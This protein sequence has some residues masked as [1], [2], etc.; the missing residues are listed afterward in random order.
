MIPALN[1]FDTVREFI[2]L[3]LMLIFFA[4]SYN[5]IFSYVR[6]KSSCKCWDRSYQGTELTR[7]RVEREI[8]KKG[9]ST[10]RYDRDCCRDERQ[11]MFANIQLLLSQQARLFW[12]SPVNLWFPCTTKTYCNCFYHSRKRVT[13]TCTLHACLFTV[14]QES[15]KIHFIILIINC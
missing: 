9:R 10:R 12:L 4:C 7:T 3:L 13:S 14:Y 5:A 2:F 11:R 15:R 6:H 8:R 1:M